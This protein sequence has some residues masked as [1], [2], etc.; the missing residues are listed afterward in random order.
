[1]SIADARIVIDEQNPW[2]GLAAFSEAAERFFNGRDAERQEL[3]RLVSQATLTVLFGKSG[4]FRRS[5]EIIFCR[6]IF[7]LTYVNARWR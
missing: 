4:C 7:A 2:P 6:S 5:R 3:R 1:M